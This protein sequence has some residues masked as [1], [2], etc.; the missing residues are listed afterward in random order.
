MDLFPFYYHFSVLHRQCTF[1]AH[2]PG[3]TTTAPPSD[4]STSCSCPLCWPLN[5]TE[6]R[7]HNVSHWFFIHC[8]EKGSEMMPDV[9]CGEKED[10][11]L[12]RMHTTHQMD[13]CLGPISE[14][15]VFQITR[16]NILEVVIILLHTQCAVVPQSCSTLSS[17]SLSSLVF[18]QM[19]IL[20]G[21]RSTV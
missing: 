11:G 19:S 18:I 5:C 10:R 16:N 7:C 9:C 6:P 13:C 20:S 3:G 14:Q 2:T 8:K 21:E 4:L 17:T 15:R 1:M 12:R